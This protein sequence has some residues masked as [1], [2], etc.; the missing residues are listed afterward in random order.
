MNVAGVL[1]ALLFLGAGSGVGLLLA[2]GRSAALVAQRDA[3]RGER[4]GLRG[5][6]AAVGAERRQ[7]EAEVAGL[8]ATLEHYERTSSGLKETF[9]ALSAEALRHNN[10]QFAELAEARLRQATT[11]ASG[12]LARR[13]QAIDALVLPLRESLTK[14]EGQI[15][16]VERER[17]DAYRS[18]VEQV[19]T[20]RRSSE[21]LKVETAQLVTALRAPQ[22][23]GRWGE[24]QLRRVVEAAGMVEHCDF[25]EQVTVQRP[26]GSALRPDVIVHLAGG[27]QVVVDAKVAFVGYL[28][29]M[30]ARDEATRAARLKAHARHLRTHIDQLAAKSYWEHFTPTPEFVVMF[31]PADA[32]LNAALE[33]DPTLQEHA[34]A[35][36]V[37]IAT[38]ST[39][40]ALLRTV[41]YTWRQEALARNAADIHALG[42][43]LHGRLATMGGHMSKLGGQLNNAVAAYNSTVSSLEGRVLVTAR[44]LSDLKV[45]DEDLPSPGQVELVTRQMQAPE[46]VASVNDALVALPAQATESWPAQRHAGG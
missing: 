28:E 11:E 22:V 44:K 16:T 25:S 1:I 26:D 8:Q 38:P 36:N 2:R 13:Q 9:A 34:F 14:V 35:R 19:G 40:I 6:L 21:Q 32:F 37:V 45:C 15:Q 4:D 27:K 3:L 41:S 20:M 12:D 7:A 23:R 10:H 24:M 31:V 39:L 30:E 46:L 18:L 33:E 43:E 42:R 5:E 17:I 29:A